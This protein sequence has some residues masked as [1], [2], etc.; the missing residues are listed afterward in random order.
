MKAGIGMSQSDSRDYGGHLMAWAE[1]AAAEELKRTMKLDY[2]VSLVDV[3]G[4]SDRQ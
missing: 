4:F 3:S 1:G 2:D